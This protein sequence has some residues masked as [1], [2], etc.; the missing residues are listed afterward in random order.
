MIKKIQKIVISLIVILLFAIDTY[1]M[2]SISGK[3]PNNKEWQYVFISL[4]VDGDICCLTI[5][6]PVLNDAELQTY[7][8]SREDT[9]K[10][11]IMTAM[12]PDAIYQSFEGE[13]NLD[14]FKAW[15]AGGCVNPDGT[16]IEKVPWVDLWSFNKITAENDM[17]TSVFF[18]KTPQELNDYIDNNWSN[19][20][21]SKATFKKL[22]KEVKN[23]VIRLGLEK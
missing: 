14:K 23:I 18:N 21:D 10:L 2:V 1:A 6:A 20:A 15:I 9:Y 8:D 3:K 19:I 13:T 16:I 12:Y 7:C 17:K 22:V 4:E 5:S 11:A